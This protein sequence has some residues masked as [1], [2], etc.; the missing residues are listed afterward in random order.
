MNPVPDIIDHN[1]K[2]L[3]I[4]F[5]PG[6]R[7]AQTGHHFAGP[8]NRFWRLL[9]E[10]GF[11]KHKLT[12]EEDGQLL[13]YGFGIT[14]I[15]SRPTRAATEITKDEYTSGTG[16]LEQKLKTYRPQIACYVGIG[17]Y[18]RFARQQDIQCGLQAVNIVP[19]VLDFVVSS[20][21]GLNRIPFGKQ[22]ACFIELQN[23]IE[24]K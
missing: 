16:I 14:N 12:P 23:L 4:G 19:G 10:S 20:P 24:N 21:S 2:I 6:L 8:S 18:R 7:S 17:V 22:L 1:L 3:F 15:V 5:N 11:T 13:Q 9:Y